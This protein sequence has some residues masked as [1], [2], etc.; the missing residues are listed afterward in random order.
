M[1]P[2]GGPTIRAV[3]D[4]YL[5]KEKPTSKTAEEFR[6]GWGIFFQCSGFTWD[7]TLSAIER[8]HVRAFRDLLQKLPTNYTLKKEYKG[9]TVQ[10]VVIMTEGNLSIDRQKSQTVNKNLSALRVVFNHGIAEF[11]LT[12]NPV[13][14]LAVAVDDAEGGEPFTTDELVQI[15]SSERIKNGQW[16]ADYWLPVM[17][18][19]T[20]ARL[21][22][23]GQLYLDD[24][25]DERGVNY[26][27]INANR[28][29][30]RLKNA[31]S[32]RRVP[33]HPELI[34][35]GFLEFVTRQRAAGHD[36]LFPELVYDPTQGYT[37][38][39]SRDFSRFRSRLGITGT[40]KKFHS[41]RHSF[42]DAAR[43]AEI[44]QAVY[45]TLQG[46]TASRN[47]GSSYGK[48]FSLTRLAEAVR[49]IEYPGV[50][51]PRAKS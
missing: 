11:D 14:L 51:V 1:V 16:D 12:V 50:V 8:P 36:R 7:S 34:R 18:L 30:K 21:N 10:E 2:A 38:N 6:R 42:K 29:D 46:H 5:A 27:D 45:D 32:A 9:K 25:R 23:L 43:E 20:G 35:L 13:A 19:F 15:F 24:I 37:R 48:G 40:G 47:V 3:W 41:F 28:P 44:E 22:E 26:L 4:S 31:E 17:G 39:Y 49:R 33:L